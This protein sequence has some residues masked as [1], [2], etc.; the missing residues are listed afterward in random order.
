MPHP[1]FLGH[2]LYG[3]MSILSGCFNTGASSGEE[4]SRLLVFDL[5]ATLFNKIASLSHQIIHGRRNC[6]LTCIGTGQ[7]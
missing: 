1:S 3:F 6:L 2:F 5:F 4:G 7:K